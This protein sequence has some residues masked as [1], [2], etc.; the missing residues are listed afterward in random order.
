MRGDSFV[1]SFTLDDYDHA[2]DHT[3]H[4]ESR[5]GLAPFVNR[6]SIEGAIYPSHTHTSEQIVQAAIFFY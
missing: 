4:P 6:Q 2:D 3:L 5:P 1:S